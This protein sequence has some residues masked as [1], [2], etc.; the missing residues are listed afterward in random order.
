MIDLFLP[1]EECVEEQLG[2]REFPD[3]ERVGSLDTPSVGRH[4]LAHVR[5]PERDSRP[6]GLAV[7]MR[8]SDKGGRRMRQVVVQKRDDLVLK[9]GTGTERG[10]LGPTGKKDKTI[11]QEKFAIVHASSELGDNNCVD[12]R[13]YETTIEGDRK[14]SLNL[15][16]SGLE[17]LGEKAVVVV[18]VVTVIEFGVFCDRT[19]DIVS[20]LGVLGRGMERIIYPLKELCDSL[21][22]ELGWVKDTHGKKEEVRGRGWTE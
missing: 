19:K 21:L 5:I 18:G 12:E 6:I 8:A 13:P 1:L 22:G 3:G 4:S 7:T 16:S 15:A 14:T 20:F 10:I 17:E 9:Q 2:R 11:F